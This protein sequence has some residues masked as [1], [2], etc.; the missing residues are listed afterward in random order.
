MT[1]C[2]VTPDLPPYT[3]ARTRVEPECGNPVTNGHASL[4]PAGQ[5]SDASTQ[6]GRPKPPLC[7][8]SATVDEGG[9]LRL[10]V[11]QETGAMHAVFG[12]RVDAE[13]DA[14]PPAF[15][16]VAMTDI[17]NIAL[18][19]QKLEPGAL[20]DA[21]SSRVNALI[22]AV[23]AFQPNDELEGMI[24]QQAAALHLV[25]MDCL[26]RGMRSERND[27]RQAHL[28][29]A[30]KCARTFGA[31]VETLNRHRG[32]VTTQKV[33]VENVTV[34]AGGQAVVGAVQGVGSNR[35]GGIQPHEN[36]HR[37]AAGAGNCAPRAALPGSDE[38]G[39]HLSSSRG[40]GAEALP[41]ARRSAR[42]RSAERKSK[43]AGSRVLH[44][45]RCRGE[46]NDESAAANGAASDGLTGQGIV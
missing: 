30:N 33:I 45:A 13:N 19:G 16:A 27:F 22:Q 42:K 6:D 38:A 44:G 21:Q 40:E 41:D 18:A 9:G 28:A 23:A 25:T 20:G 12:S 15:A 43:P 11:N 32:K 10:S 24:A 34:E 46:A 37:S 39:R 5:G 4:V 35:N 26:A 29:Q 8:V 2:D 3:R 7:E 17:I 36:T 1:D 14:P 31:L